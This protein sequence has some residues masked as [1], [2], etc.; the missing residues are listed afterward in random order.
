MVAAIRARLKPQPATRCTVGTHV[1]VITGPGA[2]VDR[3]RLHENQPQLV[4]RGEIARILSGAAG[5]YTSLLLM[6]PRTT[7]VKFRV[8]ADGTP[9]AEGAEVTL[10]SGDPQLDDEALA[11]V[12]RM[13][14]RPAKV[15]GIPV[16]VWVQVPITFQI[17]SPPPPSVRPRS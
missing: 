9:E 8:Q 11:V 10:S 1:R 7:L 14:F 4:N 17:Q 13:R 6:G 15:E 3:P 5:R 16:R 2:Q 12:G